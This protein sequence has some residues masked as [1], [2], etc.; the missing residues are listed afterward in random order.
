MTAMRSSILIAL[1]AALFAGPA[2]ADDGTSPGAEGE[3]PQVTAEQR[4]QAM[5]A[6][7]EAVRKLP[8]EQRAI[9]RQ[10][11]REARM[12]EGGDER[13]AA[14]QNR[15][16]GQPPGSGPQHKRHRTGRTDG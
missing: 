16:R 1:G 14:M 10:A 13:C 2:V 11:H 12:A 3:Q 4:Q 6:R 5:Q 7:R 15:T 9:V 8:P